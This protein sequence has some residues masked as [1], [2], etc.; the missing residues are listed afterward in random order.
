MLLVTFMLL[1][2]AVLNEGSGLSK[3]TVL[4][5]KS[6]KTNQTWPNCQV[7]MKIKTVE[8]VL[9]GPRKARKASQVK[10]FYKFY[11]I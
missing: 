11:D 4:I 7:D 3:S 6:P 5:H 10:N 2:L 8:H 1:Q 9:V